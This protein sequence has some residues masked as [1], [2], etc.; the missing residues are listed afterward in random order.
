MLEIK[1]R[2]LMKEQEHKKELNNRHK[3][4]THIDNDLND[5]I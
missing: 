4:L 1:T 2:E 3:V 5:L